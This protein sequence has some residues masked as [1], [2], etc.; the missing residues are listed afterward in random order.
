MLIVENPEAH[1]HPAGQ[2]RLGR[3]LARV[4]GSGVQVIVE[5]HSDH[6]LNGVRLA[7]VADSSVPAN[8]VIV[9]FFDGDTVLPIDLGA[10]GD[11]SAWPTGFFDQIEDD[12]GRL[13][14]ARRHR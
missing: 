12:L 5:T 13:A 8:D 14:R 11:L 9:H 10:R 6:V 2:S 4:A 1:L 3:F 7:A